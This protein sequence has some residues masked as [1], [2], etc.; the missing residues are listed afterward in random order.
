MKVRL[1]MV[2]VVAALAGRADGK[3]P[4][5]AQLN[6][7]RN[8][9]DLSRFRR[10]AR[11]AVGTG[12]ATPE[13]VEAMN[14]VGPPPAWMAPVEPAPAPRPE[15]PKVEKKPARKAWELP[16]GAFN[17]FAPDGP[18]RIPQDARMDGREAAMRAGIHAGRLSPVEI[19]RRAKAGSKKARLAGEL[20]EIY[21]REFLA[22][23]A[24]A[25]AGG[26]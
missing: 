3:P 7:A 26:R 23:F 24:S 8:D 15:A 1:L 17:P 21:E 22:G 20:A 2:L 5:A 4:S 16:G 25:L 18:D 19:R 13:Q 6:A 11:E 10:Q 14:F 12:I 9:A